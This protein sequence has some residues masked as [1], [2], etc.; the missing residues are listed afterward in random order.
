LQAYFDLKG[1]LKDPRAADVFAFFLRQ[2]IKDLLEMARR[3][4]E[5]YSEVIGDNEVIGAPLPHAAKD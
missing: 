2:K 5:E 3:I 4:D 1:S